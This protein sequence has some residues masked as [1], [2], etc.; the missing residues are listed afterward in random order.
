[1]ATK[2]SIEKAGP[3]ESAAPYGVAVRCVLANLRAAPSRKSE[4]VGQAW[5]GD[6]LAA[7]AEDGE[8]T[9]LEGGPYIMTALVERC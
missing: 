8:W 6:V 5:R 9:A 2:R 3:T 1:M 4:I 7:I